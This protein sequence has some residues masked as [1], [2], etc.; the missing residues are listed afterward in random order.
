MF[1]ASNG[2]LCVQEEV[3]IERDL[4]LGADKAHPSEQEK[5]RDVEADGTKDADLVVE[6][7]AMTPEAVAKLSE[8][9]EV[10]SREQKEEIIVE[11]GNE[12]TNHTE[13]SD[14][15]GQSEL[16]TIPESDT[17][18]SA[19]PSG[20]DN[21]TDGGKP[22]EQVDKVTESQDTSLRKSPDHQEQSTDTQ[23]TTKEPSPLPPP[24][25]ACQL[26]VW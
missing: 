5:D 15:T 22:G 24:P 1:E 21:A 11:H 10:T 6:G 2:V 8:R 17:Q 13:A 20:Q 14:K 7:H 23:Q 16:Q 26:R 25:K 12:Q 3:S 4:K 18:V 19:A 9:D